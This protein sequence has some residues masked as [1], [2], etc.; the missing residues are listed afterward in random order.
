MK[1]LAEFL[2]AS[3][4]AGIAFGNAGVAAVHA[5]SYSVG[6]AFHVPHG[7]ANYQFFTE[8][9]KMYTRK[10]PEGKIKEATKLIAGFLGCDPAGDVYGELENFLNK[11]IQKKKLREYGMVEAQID[12]FTES[13][14]ENQQRLLVNNYV[15]LEKEEVR[16]IFANLY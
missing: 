9:F 12:E 15:F 2:L 11:L 10:N 8:V 5:L 3:C 13:T 14:I 4:Y 16:E 1:H 7:E 6:G